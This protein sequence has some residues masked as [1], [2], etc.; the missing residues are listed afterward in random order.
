LEIAIS[1]LK[2]VAGADAEWMILFRDITES[3][4]SEEVIR[5]M[6]RLSALGEFSAGIA[7]EIR[8]PL[9]AIKLNLQ[10]L[11][12]RMDREP[13]SLE[14]ISDSLEGIVR[15]DKLIRSVL[16]FA[17]PTMP[18]FK[19]DSVQRV[20]RETVD[21]MKLHLK[22]KKISVSVDIAP[23]VPPISFDEDQ[24]RQVFL[25]LL[26]NAM[27]AMP[28]GGK[29]KIT[30]S[31]NGNASGKNGLFRLIISDNGIGIRREVVPK[32][33]DPFFTTKPEGTGLGLSIVHKILEQHRAI[34]E[35][36]SFIGVGTVF[37]L[38]FP[39]DSVEAEDVST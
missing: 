12:K 27:E 11:S 35:V 9:S 1:P 39:V 8:N 36:E 21:V 4:K 3:K 33:F 16:N 26:S 29:I 2:R 31:M 13:E 7:H 38:T 17:R 34:V 25:N 23:T 10:M 32:I 15:I 30:G 22:R 37:K 5:R 28:D 14:K 18:R 19:K 6:E 24:I 20:L